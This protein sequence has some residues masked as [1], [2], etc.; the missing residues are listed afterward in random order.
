MIIKRRVEVLEAVRP[1]SATVRR[2]VPR[3]DRLVQHVCLLVEERLDDPTDADIV[4]IRH[5][6]HVRA[7]SAVWDPSLRSRTIIYPDLILCI[8]L[9]V[10]FRVLVMSR[11]LALLIALLYALQG[12][13]GDMYIRL[14][15]QAPADVLTL[16][17]GDQSGSRLGYGDLVDSQ[18]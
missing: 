8:L 11:L 2:N 10:T 7:G 6:Q 1:L 14:I 12:Q 3:E 4:V 15:V 13:F 17:V 9:L 18:I 5:H 16:S